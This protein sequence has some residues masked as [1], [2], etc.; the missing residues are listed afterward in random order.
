MCARGHYLLS[1]IKSLDWKGCCLAPRLVS[2][3]GSSSVFCPLDPRAVGEDPSDATLPVRGLLE[4]RGTPPEA[5]SLPS[6]L[7]LA[8][9]SLSR[10]NLIL[11]SCLKEGQSRPAITYCWVPGGYRSQTQCGLGTGSWDPL[12]LGF[13]SAA[14]CPMYS[15]A[16]LQIPT[17]AVL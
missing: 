7:V 3:T 13:K 5:P 2:G 12:P 10:M 6:L 16:T 8:H 9:L 1:K 15:L 17:D 4:A 14:L 11:A